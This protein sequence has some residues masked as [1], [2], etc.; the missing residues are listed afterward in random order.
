MSKKTA[1]LYLHQEFLNSLMF[2]KKI[3]D[4]VGQ[5]SA[6]SRISHTLLFEKAI[7][8]SSEGGQRRS[9]SVVGL[10]NKHASEF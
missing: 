8:V 6:N 1:F 5:L 10:E 2:V 3:V 9:R 7:T 4:Y